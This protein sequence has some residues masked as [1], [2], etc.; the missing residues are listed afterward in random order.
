MKEISIEVIMHD[1][2]GQ[3]IIFHPSEDTD[4]MVMSSDEIIKFT[5]AF[6]S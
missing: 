6:G 1:N 5:S 2:D 4:Y 3:R